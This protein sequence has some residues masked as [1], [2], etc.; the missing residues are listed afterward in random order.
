MIVTKYNHRS[1]FEDLDALT[2]QIRATLESGDY[3]LSPAVEQFE[4]RLAAHTGVAHAVGVNSGTD[5]IVLALRALGIGPGDEVITV[6]NTFHASVLAITSVGARPVLVDCT[7]D[8]YLMDLDQVDAAVTPR[9]RALLAVHLFGQALDMDR[10][11]AIADRHSLAIVEDCAQAIGARWAGR[12]VG[13]FGQAGCFS[14]H[15]SK[16]LAAA[17]DGGALVTDDAAIAR[18]VRTLRSLGQHQQNDHVE[19]GYNSKLDAI[20]ALVLNH[21]LDQVDKWNSRRSDIAGEYA[22]ALTGAELTPT[23][24]AGER[25]VFHLYQVTLAHRDHV[26][27]ELTRHGVEAVVR[28]PV[29]VHRQRAFADLHLPARFPQA[30]AQAENTLCLPIRPDLTDREVDYVV[31]TL[32]KAVAPSRRNAAG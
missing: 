18:Q 26:L 16:N 14:F 29:P 28:Y 1:Q 11:A 9:T 25:H 10:I 5:A 6:A 7:P 32:L 22:R 2:H 8:S 12:R 17:G 13:S 3:I 20:Q 24:P 31:R 27:A 19:R 30:Q 21:K 23:P 15:P 4:E